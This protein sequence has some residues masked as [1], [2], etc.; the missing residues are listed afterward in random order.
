MSRGPPPKVYLH[1]HGRSGVDAFVRGKLAAALLTE[2][3]TSRTEF[4]AQDSRTGMGRLICP[5]SCVA[6]FNP[7]HIAR[8]RRL[9]A[10]CPGG[11]VG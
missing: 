5:R 8:D 3:S 9:G 10:G 11:P 7:R 2:R 1:P 6:S 4:E